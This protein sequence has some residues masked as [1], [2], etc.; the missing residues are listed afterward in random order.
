MDD[1]PLRLTPAMEDYLRAIY[2]LARERSPVRTTDLSRHLDVSP[3]SATGMLKRL[4][5]LGL[6]RHVPYGGAELS[7]A[8]EREAL[9]LLRQH[10]IIE[11]YLATALGMGWDEV[12]AE[13][14]R[15]EHHVS[16]RLQDRMADA[17]G[18]PTRDPHGAP[19][20]PR[21][22]PF[23]PPR[24]VALGRMPGPAR[25]RVNE[26]LDVRPEVLRRLAEAGLV[27]DVVFDLVEGPPSGPVTVRL[28]GRLV[29]LE[30]Q[31]AESVFVAPAG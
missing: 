17:L 30:R 15:L 5:A 8:G 29:A 9:R 14:H 24:R 10:R 1:P 27:P 7:P 26:V 19:I 23:D 20:P 22:G 11:T 16:G 6:V 21:D 28:A 25:L 2:D 12:H 3:A 4:A 18:Q 31:L 13:A